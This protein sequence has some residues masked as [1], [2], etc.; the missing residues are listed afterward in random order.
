MREHYWCY[1]IWVKNTRSI[2]VA[3]TVFFKH[4]NI[5]V[6][7]YTKADVIVAVK[8]LQD[9]IPSNIGATKNK[10]LTKLAT[11]FNTIATKITNTGARKHGTT[12]NP[13]TIQPR[14]DKTQMMQAIEAPPTI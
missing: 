14:V 9:E 8:V 11:I 12:S 2:W 7:T 1:K 5:T 4:Q 6:P 3:D 10:Q 13:Y